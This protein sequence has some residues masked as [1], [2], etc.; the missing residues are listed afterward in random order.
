MPNTAR[1][2]VAFDFNLKLIFERDF[3]M[4]IAAFNEKLIR[5]FTKSVAR[6]ESVPDFSQFQQELE[7]ILDRHYRKVGVAF[8]E[9]INNMV[10]EELG[11]KKLTLAIETKQRIPVIIASHFKV[12]A[13][14]ESTK[15]T[16]TTQAQA[17]IALREAQRLA[18]DPSVL[19]IEQVNVASQSSAVFRRRLNGRISGIV[20]L[21]T[22]E[23]AEA[24]KLTQIQILRGEEPTLAG[25]SG[26]DGTKSWANQGDSLVRL[27]PDSKFNHIAAEQTIAL[28][29]PF[30]VSG[31]QLRYPGDISLGASAGNVINCRCSV[32]YNMSETARKIRS[33]R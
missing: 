7:R 16:A 8:T 11:E 10:A 21:N 20:R 30:N 24:A 17:D 1:Q 31:Q 19:A 28:D 9:K 27:P 4:R 26:T 5:A 13:L 12:R 2:Q 23:P 6:F 14:S 32:T 15:I 3:R 18:T 22:N 25:G 29:M 33:Q